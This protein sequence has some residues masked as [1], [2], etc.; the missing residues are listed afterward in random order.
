MVTE[1]AAE[2]AVAVEVPVAEA[3]IEEAEVMVK[4][5]AVVATDPQEA[6]MLVL[7]LVPLELRQALT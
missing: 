3:E 2:V 7:P 4:E 1:E 5:E 6:L